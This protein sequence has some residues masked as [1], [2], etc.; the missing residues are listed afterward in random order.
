[1]EQALLRWHAPGDWLFGRLIDA[2]RGERVHAGAGMTYIQPA[3]TRSLC[4]KEYTQVATRVFL[5]HLESVRNA[6]R[7]LPDNSGIGPKCPA[8]TAGQL[9]DCS[10]MAA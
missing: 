1:E 10:E 5:G 4:T 2:S 6:P 8:S 9:W 7:A 3:C